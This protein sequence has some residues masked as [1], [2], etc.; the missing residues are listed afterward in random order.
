MDKT[1]EDLIELHLGKFEKKAAHFFSN[2]YPFT[3]NYI[4]M[5]FTRLENRS[6]WLFSLDFANGRLLPHQFDV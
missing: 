5:S 4:K 3:R 6:Q 1:G 2:L